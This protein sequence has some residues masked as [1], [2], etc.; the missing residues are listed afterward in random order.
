MTNNVLSSSS[1]LT[2]FFQAFGSLMDSSPTASTAIPL[3]ALMHRLI[4]MFLIPLPTSEIICQPM[5]YLRHSTPSH[6]FSRILPDLRSILY[7]EMD[8]L[9]TP[10]GHLLPALSAVSMPGTRDTTGMERMS[11][12]VLIDTPEGTKICHRLLICCNCGHS[13]NMMWRQSCGACGHA[14]CGA[15]DVM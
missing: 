12:I 8:S 14:R 1:L 4:P 3:L 13:T 15:C 10:A 2:I 6:Q 5:T 9:S 7:I 11:E